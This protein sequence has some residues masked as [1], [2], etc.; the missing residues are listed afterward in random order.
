M[1]EKLTSKQIVTVI[2]ILAVA[3]GLFIGGMALTDRYKNTIV[4]TYDKYYNQYYEIGSSYVDQG[5]SMVQK[6][7]E[8]ASEQDE[9]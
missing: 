5:Y 4:K 6:N 1:H 3:V 9:K 2:I 8:L 7:I